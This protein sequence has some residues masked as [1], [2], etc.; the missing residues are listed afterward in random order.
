[1]VMLSMLGQLDRLLAEIEGAAS[2]ATGIGTA[3]N[4]LFHFCIF[5]HALHNTR[6]PHQDVVV[7]LLPQLIGGCRFLFRAL[8]V[9]TIKVEIGGIEIDRADTMMPRPLAIDFAGSVEML[10]RLTAQLRQAAAMV[11]ARGRGCRMR[12]RLLAASD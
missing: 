9:A 2:M 10:Q 6:A 3:A 1:M 7:F 5:N 4:F 8:E 11:G 12:G